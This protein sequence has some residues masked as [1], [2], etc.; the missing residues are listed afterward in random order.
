MSKVLNYCSRNLRGCKKGWWKF[1]NIKNSSYLCIIS[2]KKDDYGIESEQEF[3]T[4]LF[5]QRGG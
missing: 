3:E 1:A 2:I 5:H 4:V